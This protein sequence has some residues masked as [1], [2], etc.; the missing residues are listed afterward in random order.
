MSAHT[1]QDQLPQ[2]WHN[3]DGTRVCGT[4]LTG[5]LAAILSLEE[6]A[7][8]ARRALIIMSAHLST[9][10]LVGNPAPI[11]SRM[12]ER[13]RHPIPGDVVVESTS[14]RY[15]AQRRA[16][17]WYRGLGVLLVQRKEW[18]STDDEW[19]AAVAEDSYLADQRTSD[20]YTYVQYGPDPG[21][22]CRWT[23]CEFTMVPL[24]DI[25]QDWS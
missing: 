24:G 22:V 3:A 8:P 6:E 15:S 18:A 17:D 14:G 25:K 9:A 16:G 23:N 10:T 20:T 19:A 4:E 1:V 12:S 11:V 5:D 13:L 7:M 2:P 21:D